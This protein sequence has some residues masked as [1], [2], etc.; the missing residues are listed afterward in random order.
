[1]SPKTGD[2][3]AEGKKEQNKGSGRLGREEIGKSVASDQFSSGLAI[4]EWGFQALL[5]LSCD[6]FS[7]NLCLSSGFRWWNQTGQTC[8]I[9][10]L[11]TSMAHL[12]LPGRPRSCL[13]FATCSLNLTS[14]RDLAPAPGSKS[15][16]S[17]GRLSK[18][19]WMEC[20]FFPLALPKPVSPG[21]QHTCLLCEQELPGPFLAAASSSPPFSVFFSS[22][23]SWPSAC[24]CVSMRGCTGVHDCACVCTH[25]HSCELDSDL[26]PQWGEEGEGETALCLAGSL[27]RDL[28]HRLHHLHHH[29]QVLSPVSHLLQEWVVC[30]QLPAG[31]E[32]P[33]GCWAPLPTHAVFFSCMLWHWGRSESPSLDTQSCS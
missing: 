31:V 33:G 30:C 10:C 18:V 16:A 15:Q 29:V 3:S 13:Y 22:G 27:Q 4:G 26:E 24:H 5:F 1:M 28:L 21:L 7:N 8:A 20:C 11:C 14:L 6:I 2:G 23:I 12:E 32:M 25:L 9:T 17:P 19:R